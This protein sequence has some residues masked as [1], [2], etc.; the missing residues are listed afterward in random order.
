MFNFRDVNYID[1]SFSGYSSAID[2]LIWLKLPDP[3]QNTIRTVDISTW[4]MAF[5]ERKGHRR[6]GWVL[7]SSPSLVLVVA[8]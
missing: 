7:E 5:A 1:V 8:N 4:V 6:A 3:S 2:P